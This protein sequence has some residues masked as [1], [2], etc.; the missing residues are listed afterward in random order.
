M[1][2]KSNKEN[3][4]DKVVKAL[5]RSSAS[6]R[7]H[8]SC[9]GKKCQRHNPYF[10]DGRFINH[11]F[12]DNE[13][14]RRREK[15]RICDNLYYSMSKSDVF[16]NKTVRPIKIKCT[17]PRRSNRI[18]NSPNPSI[19]NVT[20][21][22]ISSPSTYDS[23]MFLNNISHSNILHNL[24]VVKVSYTQVDTIPFHD[25]DTV[26]SID[27]DDTVSSSSIT[28]VPPEPLQYQQPVVSTR[29][30]NSRKKHDCL[31]ERILNKKKK[32]RIPFRKMSQRRSKSRSNDAACLIIASCLENVDALKKE[33]ISHLRNN[34]VLMQHCIDFIESLKFQL[35]S[36][37][38]V[39][40]ASMMDTSDHD[41]EISNNNEID[42]IEN[43]PETTT[44]TVINMLTDL[45][46]SAYERQRKSILTDFPQIE[47]KYIPTH[48]QM[49]KDLPRFE[50]VVYYPD[51]PLQDDVDTPTQLG[52]CRDIC[53]TTIDDTSLDP[54]FNAPPVPI[55][56][57]GDVTVSSFIGQEKDLDFKEAI[58]LLRKKQS[59]SGEIRFTRLVGGM[60]A[61]VKMLV[62]KYKR[63]SIPMNESILVIDSYDG[64]EHRKI[65]GKMTGVVSF[66]SGICCKSSVQFGKTMAESL[67]LLTH[68]QFVGTESFRNLFPIVTEIY[69]QKAIIRSNDGKIEGMNE[70]CQFFDLH[71]GKMLYLLT[72]HSLYSRLHQ[73]FLLCG[74]RRGEGVKNPDHQCKLF[75]NDDQIKYYERSKKR[76]ANKKKRLAMN[77][78]YGKAEHMDWIDR[79]NHGISHFGIHPKLLPRDELLFDTMHCRMSITRRLLNYTRDFLNRAMLNT[80]VQKQF[81]DVLSQFWSDHNCLSWI[82]GG[83]FQRLVGTELFCFVANV[84]KVTDFMKIHIMHS[85]ILQDLCNALLLWKDI[86]PMMT[87]LKYDNDADFHFKYQVFEQTLKE[88][89]ISGVST[90]LTKNPSD[91][92]N[93]ETFYCHVLRFYLP[94]LMKRLYE[95][96]GV[97]LG[98]C[99]MQGFERRNKES[100]NTMRRFFNGKGNILMTN[101]KRLWSVFFIV[102]MLNHKVL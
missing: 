19:I 70:R 46:R 62:D 85:D 92:G 49:C 90:F 69:K 30:T 61:Y 12:G 52:N 88:F 68:H 42:E 51:V 20:P 99:T 28:T 5:G 67:N 54:F 87:V 89:Y 16:G 75:S 100:K 66:T 71:D 74:C 45:S 39:S 15:Y 95:N 35:Q 53:N 21:P 96:H 33:G 22:T 64:A 10:V 17:P 55:D 86:C 84:D 41:E 44:S 14:I 57:S 77:E 24:K 1:G 94:K 29:S 47:G 32:I 25:D 93:D 34:K 26:S 59:E 4:C 2:R 63:H 58:E 43:K 102:R 31:S 82:L 38:G 60:N 79:N 8:L 76:Y 73:P 101:M 27:S 40:F 23:P 36:I 3:H 98:I 48:Y 97:G 6:K 11:Y 37:M 91:V 81:C 78:T 13:Y 72:Q 9:G 83:S 65:R 80:A 18:P 7:K 50:E 56:D